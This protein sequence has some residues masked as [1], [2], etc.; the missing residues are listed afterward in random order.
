MQRKNTT[1]ALFAGIALVAWM[2]AGS[3]LYSNQC[4]TPLGNESYGG[5]LLIQDGNHFRVEHN[6]V[7]AFPYNS[8]Q[9]ILSEQ[10]SEELFKVVRYIKSNPVKSL[11][12]IGLFLGKE[13]GGPDLGKARAEALRNVFIEAGTPEYQ[14]HTA[15]GRRDDL[16]LN[17]SGEVLLGGID[18]AFDC[19]DPFELSDPAYRFSTKVIDNFVFDYNSSQF[20]M[21]L[22]KT[23]KEQVATVAQYLQEHPDRQLKITGYNHPDETHYGALANLGLAR[24]NTVRNLF[25]EAGAPAFQLIIDGIAE[26]RLAVLPSELYDKFLPNALGFRFD[27]LSKQRVNKWEQKVKRT[28]EALKKRGVFRFK[29]FGVEEAK[30][31]VDDEL[32]IYLN[33]LILYLGSRPKSMVY[34]VGHSNQL[35]TKEESALKGK[36]RA[37]YVRNFLIEQGIAPARIKATTAGDSHPLG[38]RE[39]RYGQQINRRV[40][41]FVSYNGEEP[42]LYILPPVSTEEETEVEQ[43][44]EKSTTTEKRTVT[45]IEKTDT[46]KIIEASTVEPKAETAVEEPKEEEETMTEQDS[47]QK[48]Q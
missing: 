16:A 9:L 43:P 11:T 13:S 28:E 26:E 17:E 34:I 20:L 27:A 30:I 23:M 2:A 47:T 37:D 21:P 10:V 12:I 15:I 44:K 48:F 5:Q 6:E 22:S 41:V 46:A 40:D 7:I 36:E 35:A 8:D 3:L 45:A 14:I 29:D 42:Q 19:L 31:V 32:K 1:Y 24:A 18:F 25:L 38:K 4:C 39:T 33:E